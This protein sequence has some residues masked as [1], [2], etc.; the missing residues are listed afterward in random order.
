[1]YYRPLFDTASDSAELHVMVHA[2]H[3]LPLTSSNKTCD[4]YVV[5]SVGSKVSKTPIAVRVC[6]D[7][8]CCY[9]VYIYVGIATTYMRPRLMYEL[10]YK[11]E[12]LVLY[13]LMK[14]LPGYAQKNTQNPEWK[15]PF[16][17]T[18][19]VDNVPLYALVEV[20]DYDPLGSDTTLGVVYIP[21]C[22]S[23]QYKRDHWIPLGMGE[24][25]KV[26]C[27]AEIHLEVRGRT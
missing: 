4:S 8:D 7:G 18:V 13:K 11:N 15:Y 24:G 21:L 23:D 17:L 3:N 10:Y 6:R 14:G 1:M 9:G 26:R 16:I 27:D 5:V 2:G 22:T 12:D 19:P 25:A 20:M